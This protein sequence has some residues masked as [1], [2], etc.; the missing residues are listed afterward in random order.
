MLRKRE[1]GMLRILWGE[2]LVS[3]MLLLGTYKSASVKYIDEH[4][5][6]W[7][8]QFELLLVVYVG[9]YFVKLVTEDRN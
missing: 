7:G 8:L 9:Q 3:F 2:R 1:N 4:V 6:R 5:C